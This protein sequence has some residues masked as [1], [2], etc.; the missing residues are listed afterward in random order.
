[1]SRLPSGGGKGGGGML[2]IEDD[3][4]TPGTDTPP[5]IQGGTGCLVCVFLLQMSLSGDDRAFGLQ[6]FGGKDFA[7]D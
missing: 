2:P 4:T 7:N 6:V 5:E 1:M 3:G